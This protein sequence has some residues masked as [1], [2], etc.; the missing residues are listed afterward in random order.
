MDKT[1]ATLDIIILN[2]NGWQLLEECLPSVIEEA[3]D[4]A[5]T[6]KVFVLDNASTDLSTYNLRRFFPRVGIISNARNEYMFAYNEAVKNSRARYI[7]VL[8]NDIRLGKDCIKKLMIHFAGNDSIFA[9]QPMFL[10]WDGKGINGGGRFCHVRPHK[11]FFEFGTTNDIDNA[12]YTLSASGSCVYDREKFLRLGG[13][14][15]LFHPA[16]YEDSDISWRAWDRGWPSVFEPR[17]ILFHK[18]HATLDKTLGAREILIK[19]NQLVFMWRHM[20]ESKFWIRHITL[21][22]P[23]IVLW[24]VKKESLTWILASI[25]ALSKV[26]DIVKRRVNHGTHKKATEIINQAEMPYPNQSRCM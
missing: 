11:G 5:G 18:N 24:D 1:N 21:F 23:R 10:D 3:E 25:K 13:Y 7:M 8:N 4:Y 26:R 14:D 22:L 19:S 17:A 12:A 6:A 20:N 9:V 2:Y 16:Y 15:R